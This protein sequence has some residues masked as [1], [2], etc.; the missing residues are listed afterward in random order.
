MKK[1]T[2]RKSQTWGGLN[3]LRNG[4]FSIFPSALD[5]SNSGDSWRFFR[6]YSARNTGTTPDMKAMRQPYAAMDSWVVRNEISA[7][8]SEANT[9]PSGKPDWMKPPMAQIGRAS[10]RERV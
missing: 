8:T 5:F 4:D 2:C 7:N 9:Y 3:R 1:K 10:C 6:I